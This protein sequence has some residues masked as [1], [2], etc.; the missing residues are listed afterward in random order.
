MTVGPRRRV[1]EEA[2]LAA[3]VLYRVATFYLPPVWGFIAMRWLQRNA[4][5]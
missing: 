5:L 2:A 3:V 4:H 1:R